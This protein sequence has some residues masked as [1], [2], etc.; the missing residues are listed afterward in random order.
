MLVKDLMTTGISCVKADASL[1]QVA[2]QM[3]RENI[4]AVPVCNDMG[5]VLGII[6]DRDLVL[7]AA[8]RFSGTGQDADGVS[9][10]SAAETLRAGD[11]MT[12]QIVTAAPEMNTHQ[13]A[14]LLAKH[15]IRRLPV[16]KNGKLVGMLSI[17]DIARKRIY[18]DEAGDALSA[19]SA[20]APKL[21]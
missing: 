9:G 14:L 3:R 19:I 1:V 21:H 12:T 2:R 10:Q 20:A 6:T 11:V 4:G 5:E 17:A 13:A 15:Q 16:T 18:A 7:R 8:A